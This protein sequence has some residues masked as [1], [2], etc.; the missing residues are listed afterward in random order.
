[1]VVVARLPRQAR[2][3]HLRSAEEQ[4]HSVARWLL[5]VRRIVAAAAAAQVIRTQPADQVLP[6]ALVS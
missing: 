6:A 2:L 3:S 4:A 5:L 1:M